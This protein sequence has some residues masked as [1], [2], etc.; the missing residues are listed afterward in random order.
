E[1]WLPGRGWVSYDPTPPD[2]HPG[3]SAVLVKLALYADA[4]ETFWQEWVVS[5]DLGH[6]ATLADRMEQASRPVS[7]RWLDVAGD[8]AIQWKSRSQRFLTNYGLWGFLLIACVV[9]GGWA[10]PRLWRVFR[11][12]L[13]ARRL[14]SGQV[15]VADATL[16]YQRMLKL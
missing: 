16:L 6:Q 9:L 1:A 14:R 12:R 5:Y 7:L 4:I 13:G 11:V 3:A 8:L 15:S 2:P 10:A